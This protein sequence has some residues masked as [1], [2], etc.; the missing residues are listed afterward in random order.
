MSFAVILSSI[1]SKLTVGESVSWKW[2]DSNFPATVWTLTYTL[3]NASGQIQITASADGDDHL[4]E[5]NS[6]TAA[7]YT[8]GEYSFQA[9]VS[10]G[11]TER[12]QVD[13][14]VITIESDFATISDGVDVR[15]H[16][17]K[18]LDALEAAIEGRASKTQLE[19]GVGGVQIKH[20]SLADQVMLRDRYAIK[21]RKE[22]AALSRR[23][24]TRTKRARFV[25]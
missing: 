21:Y 13:S 16:A 8:P 19:Q 17:K 10:N 20:M 3:V 7:G 15:S 12:Y 25:S 6:T 1:P 24:S 11:S 14:G 9:H 4:V 5:V 2:S 23:S 18:V 22:V